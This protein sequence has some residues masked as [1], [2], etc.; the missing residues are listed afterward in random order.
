MQ[1]LSADELAVLLS[2]VDLH[3]TPNQAAVQSQEGIPE[4]GNSPSLGAVPGQSHNK[5]AEDM[6]G[7]GLLTDCP[8]PFQ[9]AAVGPAKTPARVRRGAR[10]QAAAADGDSDDEARVRHSQLSACREVLCRHCVLLQDDCMRPNQ[11]RH[12]MNTW[13]RLKHFKAMEMH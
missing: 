6:S 4:Q 2:T 3:S 7:Q 5:R 10:K 1:S 8:L 11:L 13:M 12:A 9:E